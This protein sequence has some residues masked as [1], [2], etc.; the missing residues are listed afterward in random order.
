[1][2]LLS[3]YKKLNSN[4]FIFVFLFGLA[5][6]FALPPFGAWFAIFISLG[7]FY[8]YLAQLQ[9]SGKAKKYT[10]FIYGWL[11]AFGY[12][13]FGL[14]W[15]G[16]ALLVEGNEYIWA[17]PFAVLGLP[18]LLALFTGFAT[19]TSCHLFKL[20]QINGYLGTIAI[21]ALT[22][23]LRGHLFTGF[24]WNLYGYS[25]S[26]A[27]PMLQILSVIGIYGL[28]ALTLLW[29]FLPGFIYI[30]GVSQRFKYVCAMF[31]VST[32]IATLSFGYIRLYSAAQYHINDSTS[33]VHIVQPNIQQKD[34]WAPEKAADNLRT[35]INLS[36]QGYVM[37]ASETAISDHQGQADIDEPSDAAQRNSIESAEKTKLPKVPAKT[38]FIIWPETAISDH[39]LSVP[40][41]QNSIR[42]M[43]ARYD[44]NVYLVSGHLRVTQ[45]P[46][47]DDSD[48]TTNNYHNSLSVFDAALQRITSYDKSHLVPFGEY[49]P[50]QKWIPL[51]TVTQFSG[52]K[53]GSHTNT[54]ELDSTELSTD[55][56]LF[57]GLICY[58]IIFPN[59]AVEHD[60]QD[61]TKNKKPAFI[62]NVTNDGWYGNS[63]GPYQHFAMARA[64][65]IEQ[66]LPVIRSANTGISGV[67]DAYGQ[68]IFRIDLITTG[69][70]T[71]R[72]PSKLQ[73][74]TIYS[75]Y[76]N[77]LF[78]LFVILHFGTAC[79]FILIKR[80]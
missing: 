37:N 71:H 68:E 11:F 24:P 72:I 66:G 25:W 22:E 73:N 1:M 74:A 60:T 23:W 32:F 77:L 53:T 28:S 4:I 33:Y 19:F 58:E 2:T 79:I 18:A 44:H 39:L 43:L 40:V 15:I 16:N 7:R 69:A 9:Q 31:I 36:E 80:S 38:T 14:Y 48:I 30:W 61:K 34:K 51:K 27:L 29:G 46:Q 54:I 75:R 57:S 12:H 10:F 52:F 63:T 3:A 47:D 76:G 56:I 8:V 45:T 42:N 20:D 50:F 26:Q 65:A 21:F 35:L 64:R 67:F 49:I 41:V 55:N 78:W 13:L 6:A 62:V 59:E 5:G 70:K 17:W